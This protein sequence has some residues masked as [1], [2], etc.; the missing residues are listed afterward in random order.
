[1]NEHGVAPTD[2]RQ[3]L[4]LSKNG[5]RYLFCYRR[6]QEQG[7]YFRLIDCVR[8]SKTEYGWPD[9]FVALEHIAPFA[10]HLPPET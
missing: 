2:D 4:L 6:G 8:D 9:L 5:H 3:Y 10:A 1:M 7:L